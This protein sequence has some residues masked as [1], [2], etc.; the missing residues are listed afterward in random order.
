MTESILKIKPPIMRNTSPSPVFLGLDTLYHIRHDALSYYQHLHSKHGDAVKV[1]LGPYRCWFIFHPD[2]IE[3]VLVKQAGSF[4]RFEK[5][6][7]ILKQW[8]GESLLIAEGESWNNRRRKVL[9]SLTQQKIPNYAKLVSAHAQD[10]TNHIISSINKK[11]TYDSNIDN[12]MAQYALDIVGISLFG[13]KLG[14]VSEPISEAVK[15]LSKIAYNETTSPFTLPNFIP[16]PA[17]RH[18]KKVIEVMKSSIRDIV[19]ERNTQSSSEKTDLLSIL[20]THHHGDNTAI[21]EDVISLLIA[22]HETSGA[23]LSWLFL[24]LAKHQDVQ[25]KVQ[26]ELDRVLGNDSVSYD[27]LRK[28]PYLNATIQETMR[29]YP[30]AYALFCRRATEDVNIDKL[31]IKKGDLV[32]ILPYVTQRDKR[33]FKNADMFN[34]DRFINGDSWPKYAYFPF[35]AGARICIGQSFGMMEVA[36]TTAIIFK[37]LS[38]L[39]LNSSLEGTP[40]F[41]LRPNEDSKVTFVSR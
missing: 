18:K 22:G 28:L 31:S 39:P 36:L 14:S 3:Q 1:R 8:N 32:Q 20:M 10:F 13:K 17:N 4:I 2:H 27:V 40:R 12:V 11:G 26:E 41:S 24:L 38:L 21:E 34:P 16:S 23:T 19:S 37:K 33:W 30:A 6:M 35:G 9:P 25:H 7:N 15:C 29:L 5:I